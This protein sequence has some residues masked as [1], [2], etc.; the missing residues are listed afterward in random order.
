MGYK[1]VCFKCRKSFSLGLDFAIKYGLTCPECGNETSSLHQKFKPPVSN[2][3]KKW[4]VVEFL[5]NQ[6]FI[7]QKVYSVII[8]NTYSKQ[9]KY[10]QAIAKAKEFVIKYKSS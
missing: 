7:F 5:K 9:V 4:Q 2:N 10:P 6:E 1:K 3:I 8:N